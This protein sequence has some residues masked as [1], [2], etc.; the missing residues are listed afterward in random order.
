LEEMMIELPNQLAWL[1]SVFY[2]SLLEY[3]LEEDKIREQFG[4]SLEQLVNLESPVSID[5]YR[6]LGKIAQDLTGKPDI[7]LIM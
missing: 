4:M 1:L 6:R 3:G 2:F 7:G 5:M